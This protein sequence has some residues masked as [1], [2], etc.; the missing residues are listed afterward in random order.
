MGKAY[1]RSTY[2]RHENFAPQAFG[3]THDLATPQC[4]NGRFAFLLV[5][6]H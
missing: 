4:H 1:P 6:E 2:S 3:N 5:I